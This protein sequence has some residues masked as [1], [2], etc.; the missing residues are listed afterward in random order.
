VLP[1]VTA[2]ALGAVGAAGVAGVAYGQAVRQA[3]AVLR[4]AAERVVG[5]AQFAETAAGV[6]ISVQA[7]GLPPGTH[8]I[9]IHD[10]GICEGP[11]FT[12]A[13]GHFNPTNRQHGFDNPQGPHAGD[14]VNLVVAA[15]GSASYT[16]T[17]SMVTLAPGPTSLLK[18]GGA[19]LMI[20]A[21]PDDYVTDPA[22]NS[23]TRIACGTIVAGAAALPATGGGATS[24]RALASP[25]AVVAAAG[26][27]LT[28]PIVRAIRATDDA[29]RSSGNGP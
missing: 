19:S 3:S 13:G 9:H 15:D 11:A 14:L 23:G 25:L 18:A 1:G 20:H 24:W 17:N 28:L 5:T 26:A 12:T 6:R 22:G 27:L 21:D 8:G 7:R 2:A 10:Q 16:T 29:D 4:D